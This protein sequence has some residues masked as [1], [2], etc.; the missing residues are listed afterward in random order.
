MPTRTLPRRF[1]LLRIEDIHQNSGTGVCAE[2]VEFSNGKCV[3]TWLTPISTV[4]VFENVLNIVSL[5][6]HGHCTLL[7][8]DDEEHSQI[9]LTLDGDALLAL[10]KSQKDT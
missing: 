1:H 10:Q 2:G 4:T 6:G 7:I 3:M 5:H 9:D 8:W